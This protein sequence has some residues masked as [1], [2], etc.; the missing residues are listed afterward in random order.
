MM[1]RV[2][3]AYGTV[4]PHLVVA[5]AFS[6]AAATS[7]EARNPNCMITAPVP[8]C[9]IVTK[10]ADEI[11]V[12]HSCPNLQQVLLCVERKP[13]PGSNSTVPD[14]YSCAEGIDP[15]QTRTFS[16]T[17]SLTTDFDFAVTMCAPLVR[18]TPQPQA[19]PSNN[20]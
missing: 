19:S 10:T 12:Q 5:L 13:K 2:S 4:V 3:M 17:K 20:D 18:P 9:M 7:A 15:N 11:T 16:L 8:S 6:L 14:W 1:T